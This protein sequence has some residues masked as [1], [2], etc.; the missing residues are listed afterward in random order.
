MVGPAL[1][2]FGPLAVYFPFADGAL[3]YHCVECGFQCCKGKGFG[4]T[5]EELVQLTRHYPTLAMFVAPMREPDAPSVDLTNFSPRCFFL[6]DDGNCRVQVEHG[7]ALKPYVC[8]TFPVNALQRSEQLLVADLNLLCP[9]RI[10][11]PGDT[12]I[13]HADAMADLLASVE[14]PAQ[15]PSERADLFPEALLCFEMGLR[16]LPLD[17]D[18]LQRIALGDVAAAKW[19]QGGAT[20][21]S[22]LVGAHRSYL[23]RL[24][25]QMIELVGQ[26]G[27]MNPERPRF[28]R[29]VGVM[30]PRLRLALVRSRP[31]DA[32]SVDALLP[33]LGRKLVALTVYLELIAGLGAEITLGVVDAAFR[34]GR[35]LCDMLA[36]IDRVPQ[37]VPGDDSY[38]LTLYRTQEAELQ[39]LL[40][41]IHDE[42]PHRRLT[43]GALFSELG[44]E[45]PS[46]RVQ[47]CQSFT[48]EALARFV[49]E[50]A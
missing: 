30:L 8:R 22:V 6:R 39:R 21:S 13:R 43:L 24:R 26:V 23:A 20:A 48:P 31:V 7:R 29:E 44:M 10:A 18:L 28:A 3:G 16:D 50:P 4:A 49:F 45:D 47:I 27:A 35:I 25:G 41:F 40:T 19:R 14:V 36:M 38:K 34:Q 46:V 2:R 12:V 5:R 15:L 42:N 11:R 17:D 32:M 37:F 33:F 9:V 1:P